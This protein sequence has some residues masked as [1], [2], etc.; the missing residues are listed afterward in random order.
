MNDLTIHGVE[1]AS[2]WS[3][4]ALASREDMSEVIEEAKAFE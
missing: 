3:M 4:M 1:T 2:V